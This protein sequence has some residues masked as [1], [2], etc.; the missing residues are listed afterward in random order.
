MKITVSG[1]AG[2]GKT[3]LASFLASYYGYD[4]YPMSRIFREEA[5]KRGLSI[6][7][8]SKSKERSEIDKVLDEETKRICRN[9]DNIVLEGRL[10]AWLCKAAEVRIWLHAPLSVR[11]KRLSKREGITYKEALKRLKERDEADRKHYLRLYDI[12]ITDLSVYNLI[13]DTAKHNI[14]SMKAVALDFIEE[15]RKQINR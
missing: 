8:F 6:E 4:Y 7:D 12:D 14:D 11:A 1:L 3:T 5:R 10:V 9:H 13:I 15:K 2:T